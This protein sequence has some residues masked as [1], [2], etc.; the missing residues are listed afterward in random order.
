MYYVNDHDIYYLS[1]IMFMVSIEFI[2]YQPMSKLFYRG[3]SAW[4]LQTANHSYV[5]LIFFIKFK[6]IFVLT[7]LALVHMR[8]LTDRRSTKKKGKNDVDK[9]GNIN[10]F[11]VIT[12]VIK[13]NFD[14]LL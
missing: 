7:H 11:I 4:S 12:E 8:C 1:Y 3:W 13:D 6:N 2:V 10:I 9:N 14:N 5:I